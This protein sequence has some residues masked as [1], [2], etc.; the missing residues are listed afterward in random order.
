[1]AQQTI[2]EQDADGEI[3]KVTGPVVIATGMNPQMYDVVHVGSEGLMGEVIQIEGDK[4]YIQVYEDTTGVKPGEPVE[5]TEKPLSVDLGPGLLGSIYDG[6]Q[7][8]LPVMQEKTGDFIERGEDAPG[9]DQEQHYDFQPSV[10]EGDT[11]KPGDVLGTVEVE[12]GEHKVMLPPQNEGG[13][14]EGIEEGAHSVTDTIAVVDGEEV[15]MQQEWPIREA[16]EVEEDMKPEVPLV[17][18]QRVLDGLFPLAK[19]GTAAIPGPFGSGKTVTQQSLAKFSDADIIVYIGCGERGNEMT[20]VLEEFPELEDPSTGDKLINR[21][22]L[23]ANTSN[24]PVA[25][26]EASIYTGVTIAEYFRDQG[27]DVAL[28]ADS[29]SRWAE[30]MREV[31]ARLEEMPGERGYPAYLASRLAAFYERAGRV[32]PL[33]VQ[34][35]GSVSII[36]AVSPPGGDFSEPV[37]QNTLRVVK[38]FWA[39]DSDLAEKRHFPSINWDDSYSGYFDMVQDYFAE[40]ADADDWAENIQKARDLL[41]KDGELQETVQL[42]GKDALPDRERLTLEIATL[43]KQFYLQQNAFHDVDEYS[44]PEKTHTILELILDWGDEAYEALENGALVENIVSLDSKNRI[45]EL[46]FNENY[47]EIEE[48]IR[49][50]MSGEFDEVV[51]E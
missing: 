13:E 23:I 20:E 48:E 21:T 37:T 47:E 7:R 28:M 2:S 9:I 12:Y 6:L 14:V 1:M 5:N 43:V 39:L 44:K 18:G 24:M 11:V 16:R 26:R 33:G 34:D 45:S 17:T 32:K 25:A 3:F 15:A 19:G 46:K 50:Q 10:E 29:T 42:V 40:E 30:A 51:E 8:P 4:A 31:S 27:L 49:D 38:N 36:G 41:Q 35:P 22:V